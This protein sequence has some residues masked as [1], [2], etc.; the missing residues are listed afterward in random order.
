MCIYIEGER[1]REDV[2]F[3]WSIYRG[4]SLAFEYRRLTNIE[5]NKWPTNEIQATVL[6]SCLSGLRWRMWSRGLRL[7]MYGH[8]ESPRLINI[9]ILW[10]SSWPIR[11]VLCEKHIVCLQYPWN[12][13]NTFFTRVP[14]KGWPRLGKGWPTPI[15]GKRLESTFPQLRYLSETQKAALR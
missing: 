14:I 1:E 2:P 15:P 9:H 6:T 7:L 8:F 13:G 4:I 3:K 11:L 12:N 10:Q 5:I